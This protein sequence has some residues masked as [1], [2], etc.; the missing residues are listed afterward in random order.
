[1]T[2]LIWRL[3]R[4]QL[5]IGATVLAAFTVLLFITGLQM[6][7][8]YHSA[9]I[10][11]AASHSCAG[12]GNTLFLGNHP[13]GFL[14]IMTL[15]VPV[16]FGLFLGA[17][18]VAAELEAGTGQFAWMQSITRKRWLAATTGWMLLTAAVWGG[19]VSGLVTWWSG[20]DNALQLDAFKPGRFDIMGIVPVGYAVF[21]MALGIAAG[22]VVRRTLPAMAITLAGF[23]IVRA[24]I[25][26]WV[27]PYYLSPVT[28][29]YNLL[30]GYTP[31]GSAWTIAQ[32]VRGPAGNLDPVP[33]RVRR[34][35]RAAR[36]P[37][38]FLRGGEGHRWRRG[39]LPAGTGRLPRVRHL[40]ARRPLLGLPGDRNRYL[41][42]PR[43]RPHR[44]RRS[45]TAPA[46]RLM[47]ARLSATRRDGR[48]GLQRSDRPGP[49]S[50]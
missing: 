41:R 9:L 21:A 6:A 46:R 11:C 48:C 13:V 26:L 12:L 25:A 10:A 34:S 36:L 3:H 19:A 22:A 7:T 50:R 5:S 23:I 24:A 30:K 43:R 8:Q 40:P 1:M 44:A 18:L 14:V 45:G 39:V 31:P 47:A 27:R 4:T 16:L 29:T 15:G 38:A 35:R 2:W 32:G 37:P 17:P 33:E 28:T 49:G 42:G 20:P